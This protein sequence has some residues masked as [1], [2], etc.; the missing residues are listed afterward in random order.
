MRLRALAAMVLATLLGPSATVAASGDTYFEEQWNLRQIGAP[1]AW[2]ASTGSG[3]RIGIVDTGVD[4][5]HEDLAGRVVAHTNCVGSSDHGFGC[6]GSGQ[7]DNGHGTH[8]AGIAAAV[9]GN[10]RG[11]AGVAPDARLVVA[12]VFSEDG[13][14]DETDVSA[15]IRWVVDHGARVVN[16][17]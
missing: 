8:V 9:M 2:A 16:L 11:I 7:D 10:R 6:R 15:G 3:V 5:A 1:A 12:K 17:S 4:L 13:R 14:G